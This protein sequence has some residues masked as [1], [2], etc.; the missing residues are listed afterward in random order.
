MG[1]TFHVKVLGPGSHIQGPGSQ[2]K[3]TSWR[4][5][6]PGSHLQVPGPTYGSWVISCCHFF[7]VEIIN[8]SV[9]LIDM[10]KSNGK[11]LLPSWRAIRFL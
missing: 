11:L 2:V 1:L 4:V 9:N 7:I 5:P 8:E 3:G 6:G 10:S